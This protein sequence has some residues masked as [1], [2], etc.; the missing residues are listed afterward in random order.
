MRTLVTLQ[1]ASLVVAPDPP[2]RW[3][4]SAQHACF[5]LVTARGFEYAVGA[6]I[7]L[8]IG[9]MCLRHSG[10]SAAYLQVRGG[11][12]MGPGKMIFPCPIV[13][14]PLRLL[15]VLVV[16][17]AVFTAL[18]GLEAALKVRALGGGG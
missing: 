11:W 5:R 4:R 1:P 6:A 3:L 13:N 17:N 18:F 7:A 16:A 8:N 15:Q 2:I 10:E 14:P 9:F 12:M